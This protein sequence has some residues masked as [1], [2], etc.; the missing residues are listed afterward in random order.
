[1]FT[2]IT[3]KWRFQVLDNNFIWK[4]LEIHV[5]TELGIVMVE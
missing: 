2:G 1:M 5:V 3:G 4:V